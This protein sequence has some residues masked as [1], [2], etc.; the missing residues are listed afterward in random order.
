MDRGA[1][2]P[3]RWRR[4]IPAARDGLERLVADA[5]LRVASV[6]GVYAAGDTAAG[7]AEDGRTVTQSCHHA[8]PQGKCCQHAVPQGKFAG[9]NVAAELFGLPLAHFAPAPYTTCLDL[10]SAGAASMTGRERALRQAPAG[11]A[12]ALKREIN[13]TWIRPPADDADAFPRLADFRV[14]QR[15]PV[16]DAPAPS[17]GR[18][19]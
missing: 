4:Q 15:G 19:A 13:E 8:V 7:P 2:R 18:T 12:K 17:A 14:S 9:H 6:P 5:Y 1:Y 16:A 10:G 3:T 11:F